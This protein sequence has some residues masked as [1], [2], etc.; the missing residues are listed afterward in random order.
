MKDQNIQFEED[1]STPKD[2]RSAPLRA[3]CVIR[4]VDGPCADSRGH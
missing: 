3:A 1:N 2:C 4:R